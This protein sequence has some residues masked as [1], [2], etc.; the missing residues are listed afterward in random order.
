MEH[1]SRTYKDDLFASEVEMDRYIFDC[2]WDRIW[3]AWNDDKVVRSN[4]GR[5]FIQQD[6]EEF[7]ELMEYLLVLNPKR[8]M[9]IG[10]ACGGTTL[11]WQAL[12]PI[13][14]SLDQKPL[15]GHIPP[16]YF[17][18]VEFLVGDSHKPE[19]LEKARRYAPVDFLF[20]D[21]DH[22]TEGVKQD[23]EMYSSLV[24]PG[25]LIGFHDYNHD[26]VRTFL[27]TL[28]GLLIMP[29]DRFGIAILEV[30]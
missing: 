14:I 25:G 12:A 20:I 18:N 7:W 5:G 28:R 23:Y 21:G 26:P 29:M 1:G 2:V 13:V 9:E 16:S 22:C 19:T 3:T 8:I 15:E 30:R 24:R 10:N 6:K 27:K 11:F 17:P 4:G